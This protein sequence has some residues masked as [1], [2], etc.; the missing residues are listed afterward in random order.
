MGRGPNSAKK[1]KKEKKIQCIIFIPFK[2]ENFKSSF[3]GIKKKINVY[4]M[5]ISFIIFQR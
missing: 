3:S 2:L 5:Y 1:E 4:I